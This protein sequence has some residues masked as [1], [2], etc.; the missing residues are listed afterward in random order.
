[1]I[2]RLL[3]AWPYVTKV[4]DFLHLMEDNM[5]RLSL[6]GAQMWLTTALNMHTQLVSH[7]H[8]VQG[9]AMTTNFG[10]MVAHGYKRGQT[11]TAEPAD[12]EPPWKGEA[13]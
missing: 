9:M 13:D 4:L 1:M 11:L 12:P 2:S 7:D 10:A 8:I 6:T 5:T 3:K